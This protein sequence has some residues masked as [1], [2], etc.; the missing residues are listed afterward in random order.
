MRRSISLKKRMLILC[1]TI[2]VPLLVMIVS[3]LVLLRNFTESYRQIVTN[4]TDANEY[5]INFEK[6]MNYTVYRVVI[7]SISL[8]ELKEGDVIEG[9][10]IRYATV[11]KNPYKMIED[12][13]ADF[14]EMQK[15]VTAN[16]STFQ[17]KGILSCL[18]TLENVLK[19]IEK[20]LKGPSNYS[21]NMPMWE[22][23]VHGVT[24]LIQN[25]IQKYIYYETMSLEQLKNV[26]EEE[27]AQAISLS[28]LLL[29]GI[30]AVAFWIIRRT[31]RSVTVPINALCDAAR[32][33]EKG[34]FTAEQAIPS[35]D[36]IQILVHR[37]DRMRDKIANLVEDIKTEQ[38]KLKD[39]EL[40]LLQEQINPHFLYNT[41]DTIVWLAEEG[42]DR[43]VVAMTT[44]LSEFFRT[45]LSGGRDYIT[46]REEVTHIRSYLSIQQFRYEDILDYEIT[47]DEKLYEYIILKLTLQPLVENALYH[48][49]KNKRGRGKIII[50]GYEDGADLILEV[51]DNGIGMDQEELYSLKRKLKEKSSHER[52]GFGLINV[53]ERIRMNYGYRYG[54]EFESEKGKGTKVKV[55]IPKKIPP[56]SEKNIL[57]PSETENF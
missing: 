14:Q 8:D 3:I 37:F 49:I 32:Q 45:V 52:S 27:T 5:N 4:I 6:D 10:D 41:L 15:N 29:A 33:M 50:N 28:I 20:N 38:M 34:D 12:A 22:N 47:I 13:R 53:E 25:Y 46:I 31:I 36:E 57:L 18:D 16:D 21:N 24:S 30:I 44:S 23:D 42:Q 19:K 17:I 54:M 11:V 43:D 26:I 51:I 9:S 55:R 56:L 7:G 40:K 48:G 35:D 39:T 2:M 1:F